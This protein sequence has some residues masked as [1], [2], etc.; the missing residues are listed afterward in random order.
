MATP[1]IIVGIGTS[2]L[3]V[4]EHVQKFYYETYKTNKPKNVEYIYLETNEDNRPVGT[5][6]GN[7]IT[8]VY[9]SLD[10]MAQMI[11]GIKNYCNNPEWLPDS[12]IVLGA[13]LGAGGIRSCG[14]LALWGKNNNGDNFANIINAL[15]NAHKKVMQVDN[16]DANRATT[17]TVFI[18]G[19]LTGGTGSGILIDMGYLVRHSIG[20][21]KDL[22]GLFLLPKEPTV[23]RG[24]EVMY[25][26]TY[27]AIRDLEYYN[28]TDNNYV[29]KWPNGSNKNE[30]VPP[31]ELVQFI[32]QDYKD[33][34][35]AINN[36][37]G[38]YKMAG[39]YLFL[40]IAG[41]Y[42]KRRE[43]LVDAAGNS[44]IGKYGTFGLSAI[45][46][47]KDQIQD[48]IASQLGIE[49]LRRLT[50]SQEFYLN[51]QKRAINRGSIKKDMAI[52]FD[53]IL[54][55]AFTVL[56]TVGINDLMISIDKDAT[57]INKNEIK[58]NP[59]E[60]IVSMFTSAKNDNYHALVSNN[61]KSAQD[62]FID[63]IYQQV[64][65]ALQETENLYYARF[66]LEDI[67]ESIER[68]LKYWKSLGISS[69]SQNWDNELRKMAITCTKNTYRSVFEQDAVLKDRLATIFELM[70]M[71]LSIRV[72]VDICKHVKE[73]RIKLE[74]ASY[75][76]P[77]L[78]LFDNLI[79][80][81]NALI[82][83][84]D[85]LDGNAIN[86]TRRLNDIKGDIEDT[87]L[88]ILRVYPSDSFQMEC[89]KAKETYNQKSGNNI[90]SM[91][92]VIQQHNIM[93][94]FKQKYAGKF[95]EEIYLDFIRAFRLK[96]DKLECIEDFNVASYIG[97]NVDKSYNTAKK[98]TSPFLKVNTIF[99]PNP[100]L[101]R[102]VVG[103]DM[104]EI[105][106]ILAA[107]H[108]QNYTDF[109]DSIGGKQEL[110]ELKNIIVFYDEQGNYVPINDL[111]YID[112]MEDA[113]NRA[114][115]DL[116]DKTITD[117]IWRNNR[118]AYK[119]F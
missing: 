36:L 78:Q 84:T 3:Y 86:F 77:K 30:A 85:D 29:E 99:S 56:N 28:N 50:N 1:A 69:Q 46:F 22:Y 17:P 74:G 52:A 20:N 118:N 18:T 9:I 55:N 96:V 116:A 10:N 71:H 44:V 64:D 43:R 57:R 67:V 41:I 114:P 104:N 16:N 88:P 80:K 70:K 83:K 68:T 48:F 76:L 33:G 34:S 7:D 100:Y 108:N 111:K 72:L 98:S 51:G 40:N 117:D 113:Y 75:E 65:N 82:G 59:V 15:Q 105:N 49:L 38:L 21:V 107:F 103:D 87:T 95:N 23:M 11:D 58:G 62:V 54:E 97:K 66:V 53:E 45:Q 12:R 110:T 79:K 81:L 112:L 63:S 61:I 8:R 91:K 25:G 37:N 5:P 93:E 14:R 109:P 106:A 35:P 27:G 32:S 19:S 92:D 47:P 6:V 24:Y 60:F 102:F 73:G 2:G 115:V 94:Y 89:E 26:N 31:Y 42:E 90:R 4:L 101:P 119:T 13:G 39:L